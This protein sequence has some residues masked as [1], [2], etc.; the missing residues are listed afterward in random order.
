MPTRILTLRHR[1]CDHCGVYYNKLFD[2][3]CDGRWVHLCAGCVEP[4]AGPPTA[5]IGPYPIPAARR[6][7]ALRLI[8]GGCP[9]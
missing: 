8:N 6:A 7:P 4:P 1:P 9:R 5:D 2:A 3:F